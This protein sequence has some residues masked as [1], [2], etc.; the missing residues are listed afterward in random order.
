MSLPPGPAPKTYVY[1]VLVT[2]EN[3]VEHVIAYALYKVKKNSLIKKS[4]A[5][6]WP[7]AVLQ[8]KL[9]SLHNSVIMEED[10]RESYYQ[11]A[12]GFAELVVKETKLRLRAEAVAEYLEKIDQYQK[13]NT[14]YRTKVLDWLLSGVSGIVASVVVIGIV[15]LICAIIVGPGGREKLYA[16]AGNTLLD[17]AK[18]KIPL[19][20]Y[21]D[22]QKTPAQ[23]QVS[24]VKPAP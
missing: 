1:N 12:R 8:E 16:S 13:V 9:D 2:D 15:T 3:N 10:M 6:R 7:S 20:D 4:R 18:P 22:G 5:E 17:M 24:P 21:R 14:P 23:P 19:L 11:K